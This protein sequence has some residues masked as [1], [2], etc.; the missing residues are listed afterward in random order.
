MDMSKGS[1]RG[2]YQGASCCAPM[3]AFFVYAD[4]GLALG[5]GGCIEESV[6][7]GFGSQPCV[8]QQPLAVVDVHDVIRCVN[9]ATLEGHHAVNTAHALYTAVGYS[10]SIA[11]LCSVL[12]LE[13]RGVTVE[14]PN[15]S[16]QPRCLKPHFSQ[17]PCFRACHGAAKGDAVR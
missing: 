1:N 3:H 9:R 4:D 11:S 8:V 17:K 13:T 12:P 6:V 16:V 2:G 15:N 7:M 10:F 14:Q 5:D